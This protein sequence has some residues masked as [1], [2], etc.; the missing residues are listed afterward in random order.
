M[1]QTEI[2]YLEQLRKHATDT[3]SFLSNKMKPERERSVCRAFLRLIGIVFEEYEL[4]APTSEPA[5]VA[6]RDAR[7][8]VRDLLEPDRRRGDDWKEKEKKYS[9]AGSLRQSVIPYSPATPIELHALIREIEKA[10]APKAQKYGSGCADVD[11]L[12]YVDLKH[13]FLGVDSKMPSTD[14]LEAQGWRS[15]SLLFLPY[16]VV[17]FAKPAAPGLLKRLAPGQYMIWQDLQT[18]FSP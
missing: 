9:E 18:L 8:Q 12:V 10:L 7:F 14:Q 11:A 4:I 17:L 3:R 5:D 13:K 16:A 2:E 15:V 6:F 1:C